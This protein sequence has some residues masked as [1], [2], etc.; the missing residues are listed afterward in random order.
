MLKVFKT[1]FVSLRIYQVRSPYGTDGQTEGWTGRQT[2]CCPSVCQT[3]RWTRC[4]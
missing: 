4:I 3:D 2:V 1:I